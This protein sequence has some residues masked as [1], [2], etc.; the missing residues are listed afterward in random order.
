VAAY[1]VVMYVSLILAA[2][3]IGYS[4]GSAPIVSFNFGAENKA[5]MKN[6]FTKSSVMILLSSLIMTALSFILAKPLS[7]VFVGYDEALLS[8]TVRGFKIFSFSFLF[9]GMNIFGSAFFTALNNGVVSAVISFL[10]T[11]VFQCAGVLI[12]PM[13]F[14]SGLD[15]IWVSIIVAE[16]LAFILTL[17][18]LVKNKK[19]YGYM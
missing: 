18:L 14:K 6:V 8:I 5:E 16:G 1:G 2:I 19:K 10:R 7:A 3:F 17:A 11:F 15:G 13:L 4:I 12:L 9:C